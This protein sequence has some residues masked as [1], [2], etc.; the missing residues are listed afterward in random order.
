MVT[1]PVVGDVQPTT[2]AAAYRGP[3]PPTGARTSAT[4]CADARRAT[5]RVRPQPRPSLR[6]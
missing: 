2:E 6:H 5:L 4:A 1:F 3:R